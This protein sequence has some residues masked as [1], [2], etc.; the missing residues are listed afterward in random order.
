[1][2]EQVVYVGVDVAKAYLDVAWEQESWRVANDATG[3]NALVKRLVQ[4]AGSVQVICEASGGYERALSRRSSAVELKLV[5]S[6]PVE[7]AN[8]LEPVASWPKPIRSCAR[9]LWLR[10]SHPSSRRRGAQAS[11]GE[12]AR[13]G[14]PAPALKLFACGR[15]KSPRSTHG[16]GS[17]EVEQ[18]SH[19]S[20][21]KADRSNRF[22]RAAS[23]RTKRRTHLQSPETDRGPR[24][25]STH[26]CSAPGPNA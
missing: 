18:A 17:P 5:W 6:R 2:K 23:N 13:S 7:C 22:A 19:R 12:T 24:G 26:G 20:G 4:I 1:M 14:K 3:T 9:A 25:R 8:T 11:P 21:Q 16:Q 10:P 15:A